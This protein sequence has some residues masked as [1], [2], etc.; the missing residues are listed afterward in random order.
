MNFPTTRGAYD[1]GFN[2]GIE[3]F[4]FKLAP[5]GGSLDFSTLI[6]GGGNDEAYEVKLDSQENIFIAG[7]SSSGNLT[8][9]DDAIDTI[10]VQ[11]EG[12]LSALDPTGATLIYS[13]YIG[14][15]GHELVKGMDVVRKIGAVKTDAGDRPSEPV[16]IDK[17]TVCR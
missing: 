17:V 1:T 10:Q 9:T 7:W 4:V 16:V 2:G 6:G 14:G 13:T 5:G 11:N 3:A 12:F 8:L 15:S